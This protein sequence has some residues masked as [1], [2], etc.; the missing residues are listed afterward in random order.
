MSMI[1]D[2]LNHDSHNFSGVFGVPDNQIEDMLSLVTQSVRISKC[3]S[4][5]FEMIVRTYEDQPLL[6]CMATLALGELTTMLQFKK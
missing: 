5:A 4:Q 3:K 6:C 1:P 2:T